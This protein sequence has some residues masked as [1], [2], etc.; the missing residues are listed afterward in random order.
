MDVAARI[1]QLMHEHGDDT[2]YQ[3][4]KNSGIPQSTISSIMNGTVPNLVTLGYFCEY[5][6]ITLAQLFSDPEKD[7]FY[8][9]TAQQRELI[10][11]WGTLTE[12]QQNALINV[13]DTY[14]SR[15]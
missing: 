7:V 8:P 3:L 5:F 10:E 6:G 13:I 11:K 15:E 14:P 2:D 1:R 12:E 4:S 9:L